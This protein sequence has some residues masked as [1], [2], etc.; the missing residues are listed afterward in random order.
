MFS[1]W[2]E[3]VDVLSYVSLIICSIFFRFVNFV[4]QNAIK[5]CRQWVPCEINCSYI[6]APVVLKFCIRVL[7]G[8][9]V[10]F[11]MPVK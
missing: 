5:L 3:N 7:D 1:G 10:F 11:C 8:R 4:K 2:S 6:F 9:H